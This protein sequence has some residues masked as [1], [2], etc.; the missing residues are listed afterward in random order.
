MSVIQLLTLL[1]CK[2]KA[3]FNFDTCFISRLNRYKRAVEL[4]PDEIIALLTLW[5]TERRQAAAQDQHQYRP[6]WSRYDPDLGLDLGADS[7]DLDQSGGDEN[8]LENPVY[9]HA[10]RLN[11][12][13]DYPRVNAY[14]GYEDRKKRFM[15]AKK[16]NDPTRE[17]R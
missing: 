11:Q 13:D 16:R 6:I 10:S 12:I 5:E 2:L 17:I 1:L 7:N 4:T 14:G 15:V 8:W 9:P 3:I